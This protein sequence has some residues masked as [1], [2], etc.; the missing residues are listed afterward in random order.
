MTKPVL[1]NPMKLIVQVLN[2]APK[3]KD[4]EQRSALTYWEEDYP[5]SLDI[6]KDKYGGPFKFEQVENVKLH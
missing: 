4:P 6:G 2:Y 1:S 3:H 5:T